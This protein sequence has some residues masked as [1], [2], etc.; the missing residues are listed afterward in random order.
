MDR[1]LV[2]GIGVVSCVGVGAGAYW[3][4]LHRA[5]STP[6]PVSDPCANMPNNLLYE[7]RDP[8]PAAA[9]AATGR[10]GRSS[11]Y[12]LAAAREAVRDAG[13][14]GAGGAGISLG[15]GVG[16]ESLF[17]EART[18]GEV[19]GGADRFRFKV[20]SVVAAELG[21]TGPNLSVSTA[22]SASAY[23][24]SLAA[25]AI[26]D[27][28]ADV[29]V[30]GGA[31]GYTRVGVACFNRIGGL[32]PVRCRPFDAERQGTLFGEGAAL[33]VLES[34]AHARARGAPKCYATI[35]GSGWSCDG[36]HMTA[37]E[38]SGT[39]IV[40]AMRA[41]LEEAEVR[42]EQVGCVVPHG[43]GTE[44]NDA[45][46]S[47]ALRQVFG[48]HAEDLA[49]YSLKAMLG[50]TG[51]AAGAFAVAT[52]ALM[53]SNGMA[54]PNVAVAALDP[55]CPFTLHTAGPLPGS[56]GHALVNAYGFG[57]NNIS[58]VLGQAPA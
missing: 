8:V 44:L 58:V 13:L 37:P 23:S 54:P 33:M 56:F 34:E 27:G 39:Q 21:L 7:I 20:S 43:T 19:P 6:L 14:D 53:L 36:H 4:G 15:T 35:E 55:R 29:I 49:V 16:D 38:P 32:D 25:R 46:E 17:E 31:D 26:G 5:R 2:T 40:R 57:G 12:A 10:L 11:C 45:V 41:A 30:T 42:P 9:R 51:G 28:E 1:I 24:V 22:C 47:Q 52:A 3:A 18:G 50:H 48:P